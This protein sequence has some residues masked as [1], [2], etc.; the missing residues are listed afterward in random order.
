MGIY[1]QALGDDFK[2]LG[3]AL[4]RF[5]SGSNSSVG[6]LTVTHNPHPVSKLFVWLMQLP[7]AGTHL[8]THLSVVQHDS[9]EVWTRKIGETRLVTRQ[10]VKNGKLIEN[11]GPLTFEFD[12]SQS[13]GAMLF[14]SYRSR[15]LGVPLPKHIAPFIEADATP[16]ETGWLVDVRIKCPRYG[17][18]CR[19]E[20]NVIIE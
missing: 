1:Q 7:K 5:H 11:A 18:I 12:L 14:H 16:N 8:E 9:E 3:E 17:C 20:G 6:M 13:G 19:Y 15:I 2:Q 10:R 4:Q